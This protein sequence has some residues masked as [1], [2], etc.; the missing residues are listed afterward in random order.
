[1]KGWLK[2]DA[3]VVR[4]DRKKNRRN[5]GK[6]E[7]RTVRELFCVW[8]TDSVE[9]ESCCTTRHLIFFERA[10]PA[11]EMAELIHRE[12]VGRMLV[13][14]DSLSFILWLQYYVLCFQKWEQGREM[15]SWCHPA[16]A[17]WVYT[18]EKKQMEESD[19]KKSSPILDPKINIF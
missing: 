7:K 13:S 17:R 16:V 6:N 15:A 8:F 5:F 12:A 9:V 14:E 18:S 19:Y 10:C 3:Q 4:C 11:L 2:N 1:M